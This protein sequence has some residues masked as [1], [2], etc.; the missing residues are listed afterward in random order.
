MQKQQNLVYYYQPALNK[1]AH[2]LIYWLPYIPIAT[3]PKWRDRIQ[4]RCHLHFSQ[5]ELLVENTNGIQLNCIIMHIHKEG[6]I[7]PSNR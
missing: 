7:R 1:T 4:G 5:R 2:V 3:Q 6:S